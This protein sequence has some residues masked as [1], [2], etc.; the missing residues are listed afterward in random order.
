MSSI[1][2]QY[3]PLGQVGDLSPD[4]SFLALAREFM[5]H[6]EFTQEQRDTPVTRT[7]GSSR[8]R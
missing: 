1:E 2:E 8:R 3:A 6:V 4:S 7:A 5:D